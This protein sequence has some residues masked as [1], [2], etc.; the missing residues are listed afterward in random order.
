MTDLQMYILVSIPLAGILSNT[1]LYIPLSGRMETR[2]ASI[3][4]RLDSILGKISDLD[5]RVA[6]LEDRGA[7]K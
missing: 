1:A 6:V 2:F 4:T 3:G 5:S 7:K